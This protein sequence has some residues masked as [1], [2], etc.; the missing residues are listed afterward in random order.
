[1]TTLADHQFELLARESDVDGYVFGLGSDELEVDQDGFV[2]STGD[3]VTQDAQNS[4]NGAT[5]FGMDSL[6]AGSWAFSSFI[7]MDDEA[8]AIDALSRLGSIWRNQ[9]TASS[10][11]DVAVLRYQIAGRTRRVYGRPRRFAPIIGNL[12]LNGFV[13]VEHDFARSDA[14]TYDDIEDTASVTMS[15][16][17][18]DGGGIAFPARFPLNMVPSQISPAAQAAVGGD[19][20][21]YPIVRFNG[22]WIGPEII[23]DSWTISL[24]NLSLADGEWVEVDARPW[25]NTVIDQEGATRGG[26]LGRNTYLEDVFFEPQTRPEFRISGAVPS[27]QASCQLRW[28]SAH[29]AL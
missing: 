1:M 8:S 16:L 6:G 12:I 4:R 2:P 27:G 29:A 22:P 9:D 14:N 25:M 17:V 18:S 26:E 5:V 10:Y 19:V 15:A 3:W 13:A 23:A 24:P 11:G 7:N 28:R 21:T 20:R